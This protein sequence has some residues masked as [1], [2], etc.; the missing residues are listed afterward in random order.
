MLSKCILK[1]CTPFCTAPS[2]SF[3]STSILGTTLFRFP[4]S[5]MAYHNTKENPLLESAAKR[6]RVEVLAEA[7]TEHNWVEKADALQNDLLACLRRHGPPA[8]KTKLDARL[9]ARWR[10]ETEEEF[11]RHF[12]QAIHEHGP[13]QIANYVDEKY[14]DGHSLL[15]AAT[16]WSLFAPS[17]WVINQLIDMGADVNLVKEDGTSILHQYAYDIILEVK[18]MLLRG[19]VAELDSQPRKR[20]VG[21]CKAVFIL[22]LRGADST[23]TIKGRDNTTPLDLIKSAFDAQKFHDHLEELR[24]RSGGE[25]YLAEPLD[26][27]ARDYLMGLDAFKAAF[28]P[29]SH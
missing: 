13:D 24:I 22:R 27:D 14:S 17:E 16:Q 10:H 26:R 4:T 8:Y 23:C 15:G 29:P 2:P 18:E 20:L 25:R 9:T 21:L 28:A 5:A 19:G 11:R 7:V 1:K 6:R 12:Y 3:F